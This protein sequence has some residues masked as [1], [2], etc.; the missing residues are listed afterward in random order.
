M[1]SPVVVTRIQN[2][3]GTQVQFDG[4]YPPGYNGIGGFGSIVGYNLT[5]FPEVLLS[6]E[7]ALCTDSRRMFLGNI[8]GEYIELEISGGGGSLT[9]LTSVLPPVGVFTT[10]PA[11]TYNATPF[12]KIVYDVTD[13][14]A[15]DWNTVGTTFSRNATLEITATAPFV[16]VPAMPPFPALT[17]VTLSDNGTEINT[18]LPNGLSFQAVYNGGNTQIEIQYMHNFAGNLTLNTSTI[19]WSTF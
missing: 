12:F 6:G 15:A 19:H 16:P 1:A 8:N 2:R 18:V 14:P 9:P 11:L 17:P 4:L 13:N 10:I 7:L 5:N 3:R